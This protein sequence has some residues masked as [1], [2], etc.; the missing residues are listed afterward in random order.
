MLLS[1]IA[2][3]TGATHVVA[4]GGDR[5]QVLR[6]FLSGEPNLFG[7]ATL[8]FPDG[9]RAQEG[10]PFH[11]PPPP[12]RPPLTHPLIHHSPALAACALGVTADPR[13]R[14]V[15][16]REAGQGIRARPTAGAGVRAG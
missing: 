15:A 16:A 5:A 3:G 12:L 14:T 7:T 6:P 10:H 9:I 4:W 13:L 11:T 8:P 2:D 1:Q